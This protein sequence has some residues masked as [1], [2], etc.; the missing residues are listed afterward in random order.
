MSNKRSVP[1]DSAEGSERFNES[2]SIKSG[3][4]TES[5]ATRLKTRKFNDCVPEYNDKKADVILVSSD[6]WEFRVQSYVLKSAR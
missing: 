4:D 1:R 3:S 5:S 6:G 2:S